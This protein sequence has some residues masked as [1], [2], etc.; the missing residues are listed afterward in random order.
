[1]S[2]CALTVW[3]WGLLAGPREDKAGRGSGREGR[4]EGL[5]G[6][7]SILIS[8]DSDNQVWLRGRQ[9]QSMLIEEVGGKQR[10]GQPGFHTLPPA[11][12]G[13]VRALGRVRWMMTPA[14]E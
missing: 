11:T 4:R 8:D 7:K 12:P 14:C 5:D 2:W 13:Q 1:M 10:Q 3:C 6:D 9:R